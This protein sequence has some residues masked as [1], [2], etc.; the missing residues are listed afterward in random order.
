[1]LSS[2]FSANSVVQ[3]SLIRKVEAM[4]GPILHTLLYSTVPGA[5]GGICAFLFAL[6]GGIYRNN[7]YYSKFAIETAGA[8]LTATFLTEMLQSTSYQ[9]VA[10]FSIGVAWGNVIQLARGRITAMME[11]I[12]GTKQPANGTDRVLAEQKPESTGIPR[13]RA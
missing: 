4:N 6:R 8:L 11:G 2:L 12:L 13:A 7:R 1:L 10:A 3:L 5:A 9:A